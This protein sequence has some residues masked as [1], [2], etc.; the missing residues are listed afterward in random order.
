MKMAIMIG[1]LTVLLVAGCVQTAEETTETKET[2]VADV[3]E[4][5]KEEV[6]DA[7]VED[8]AAPITGAVVSGSTELLSDVSCDENR[9]ITLTFT[10]TGSEKLT[11]SDI[12]FIVNGQLDVSPECDADALAAGES[13]L[14]SGLNALGVGKTNVVQ[15]ILPD[16]EQG[17]KK[18]TCE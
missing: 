14:C 4:D 5:Q 6:I 3:M 18:V 10:N 12:D 17:L 9:V 7:E 1:L 11:V 15:V 16:R 8:A 13:T 2:I